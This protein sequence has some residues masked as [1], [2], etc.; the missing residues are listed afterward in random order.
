MIT[1]RIKYGVAT[2]VLSVSSLFVLAPQPAFAA[3]ASWDGEGADDNFSTAANWVGDVVPSDGD[4]LTFD[5]TGLGTNTTLTNDLTG[6]TLA[7]V[8]FTGSGSY[9]YTVGGNS[10]TIGGAISGI[11][12]LA[13]D[14]VLSANTTVD[15]TDLGSSPPGSQTIDTSGFN[16]TFIDT[17]LCGSTLYSNL[18]G[19]GDMIINLPADKGINVLGAS[20]SYTGDISVLSGRVGFYTSTALGQAASLTI[21]GGKAF[22]GLGEANQ[23]I[24]THIKV[25]GMDSFSVSGFSG[26]GAGC[27]G[28]IPDPIEPVT[29][30]LSGG[31]ELLSNAN[32]SGY[33]A[34]LLVHDPYITNGYTFGLHTSSLGTLTLPGNTVVEPVPQTVEYK[35][36]L[37]AQI[38]NVHANTTAVVTGTYGGVSVF[39]KGILKGT[40]T[41]AWLSVSPGGKVAPGLSPGVLNTGDLNISGGTLEIEIGGTTPG[42]GDGH[43]DQ[44]NVTGTVA[45]GGTGTTLTTLLWNSYSPAVGENYVIINNDG[46]D[47]VT[48][49]FSGLAQDASFTQNGVTFSISYT[50]GDGNDVVLTVTGVTATATA[51]DTGFAQLVSSPV[52]A[53][54]GG[55]L[56]AG[57]TLVTRRKLDRR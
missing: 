46:S 18:A 10:I 41:V 51:P 32:Y 33:Y 45:L 48:G 3:A 27:A 28:G 6:L 21:N 26:I 40:G 43:H 14:I 34:N 30:T 44:T 9:S 52:Y 20:P 2:L 17:G 53:L 15:A 38:I 36:N 29:L 57:S 13:T 11:G 7:G 35:D 22:I 24:A 25:G 19:S 49:T 42:T 12:A 5:N 37:P 39:D 8:S 54:V 4:T 56:I 1:R 47:A 55:V 50:G 23:T 31:L 16:I